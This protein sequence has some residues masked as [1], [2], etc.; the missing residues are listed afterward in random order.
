MNVVNS[1]RY[2]ENLRQKGTSVEMH[3]LPDGGHGIGLPIED[4][5]DFNHNRKWI[6]LLMQWLGYNNFFMIK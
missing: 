2:A 3:I 1:L 5:K 4:R 6:E